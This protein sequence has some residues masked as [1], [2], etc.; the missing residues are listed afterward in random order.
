MQSCDVHLYK[1]DLKQRFIIFISFLFIKL[2][3]I[4]W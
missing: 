2:E 1:H 3:Q 4:Y